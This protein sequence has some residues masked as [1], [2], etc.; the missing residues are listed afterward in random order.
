MCQNLYTCQQKTTKEQTCK[1]Q[2]QTNPQ[3]IVC[4]TGLLSQKKYTF[5]SF[6][7]FSCILIPSDDKANK[8]DYILHIIINSPT[9][10]IM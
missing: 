5:T 2:H 1:Q 7:V 6:I 3:K 9:N 8:R 4:E 10:K